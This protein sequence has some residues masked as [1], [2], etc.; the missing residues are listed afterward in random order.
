MMN[1]IYTNF[2]VNF[3]AKKKIDVTSK[4]KELAMRFA[5]EGLTFEDVVKFTKKGEVKQPGFVAYSS[6]GDHLVL[7]GNSSSYTAATTKDQPEYIRRWQQSVSLSGWDSR[8]INVDKN[9]GKITAKA[10]GET[11]ITAT[12]MGKTATLKVI[13]EVV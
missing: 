3:N 2:N 6:A 1:G 8:I 10:V 7:W 11:T 13:V 5:S 9:T 4:Q 12:Y